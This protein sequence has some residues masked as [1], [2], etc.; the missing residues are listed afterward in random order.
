MVMSCFL[1]GLS[2][3]LAVSEEAEVYAWWAF[4]GELFSAGKQLSREEHQVS[5]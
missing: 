5:F 3:P 1:G 4:P 2:L